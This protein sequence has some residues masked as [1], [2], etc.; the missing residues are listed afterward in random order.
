MARLL[1]PSGGRFISITFAQPHFRVP[2]YV[3]D[4]QYGWDVSISTFGTGFE[5]FC[6]TMTCGQTPSDY[7]AKLRQNYDERK[8][9]QYPVVYLSDSD[10][11]DFL[12]DAFNFDE[13]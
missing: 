10:S 4:K 1:L 6:Y 12:L 7:H 2:L 11:E 13:T 8:T 3:A 5:Y 9:K